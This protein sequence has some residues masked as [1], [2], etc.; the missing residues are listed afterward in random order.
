MISGSF[1]VELALWL[2]FLLPG[3]IYTIWRLTTKREGCSHCGAADVVPVDSPVGRQ[4]VEG[5]KVKSG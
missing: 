4:L 5:A 1:L 3:L 2:F